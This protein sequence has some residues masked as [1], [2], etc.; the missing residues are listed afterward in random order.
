MLVCKINELFSLDLQC[1]C[2]L[3]KLKMITVLNKRKSDILTN[4]VDITEKSIF[5]ISIFPEL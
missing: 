5:D 4:R 1:K 3:K 2:G